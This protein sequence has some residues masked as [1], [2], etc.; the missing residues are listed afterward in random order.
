MSKK[1][2]ILTDWGRVIYF[3]PFKY[4]VEGK[5]VSFENL[6]EEDEVCVGITTI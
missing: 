1:V 4:L 6:L 2:L 5:Q 3:D